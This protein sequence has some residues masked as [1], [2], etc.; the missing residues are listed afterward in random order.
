M[1]RCSS[2]EDTETWDPRPY[3]AMM[4]LVTSKYM[5]A[6]ELICT[7]MVRAS[8]ETV[9]LYWQGHMANGYRRMPGFNHPSKPCLSHIP[10]YCYANGS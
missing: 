9:P 10:C 8:Y 5:P 4:Q 7:S 3:S 2:A 1:E 6:L